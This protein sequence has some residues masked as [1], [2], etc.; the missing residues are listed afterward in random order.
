LF[1]L[2]PANQTQMKVEE[3]RGYLPKYTLHSSNSSLPLL[4]Y[5]AGMD[6]TGELFYKQIPALSEDY[7]VV[8]FRLRDKPD[9]TFEDLTDDVVAIIRNL[10]ELKAF[11]VGESF[12]G[13]IAMTFAIRYPAM[14][15]RLIIINSFPY[16]HGRFRINL[17]AKLSSIVT[18]QIALP[19]R[20]GMA[21]LGLWLDGVTREDRCRV[22]QALHTIEMKS[23][24]RRLRL[25]AE[26]NLKN[27]LA[28]IQAPTLFI[29]A[30]YDLLVPS[31]REARFMQSRVPNATVKIIK[32]A[33]H[34][35]LLGNRVR[36]N[37]LLT[38]W[39]AA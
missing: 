19:F 30:T 20:L 21:A 3:N 29:A 12:G 37:E 13:T 16:Y 4:I 2:L 38:E 10:N 24:A 9:A 14:T 39:I 22:L 23:Y 11:I 8:T 34:A 18:F 32:G 25:I 36:L 7:R 6:G 28:E 1:R 17:A 15:E 35:C 5:I 33:G 27:R 31:V 26:V